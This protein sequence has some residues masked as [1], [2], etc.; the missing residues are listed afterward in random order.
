MNA[1]FLSSAWD[2]P[3]DATAWHSA[4]PRTMRKT[5][6]LPNISPKPRLAHTDLTE[7]FRRDSCLTDTYHNQNLYTQ[8]HGD[9]E[10]QDIDDE[11]AGLTIVESM[12][13]EDLWRFCTGYDVI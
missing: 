13:E 8:E 11:F 6:R 1:C 2:Q 7:T 4:L 10:F 3:H 12:S 9:D 5:L